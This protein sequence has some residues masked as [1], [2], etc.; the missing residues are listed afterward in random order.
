M[1]IEQ[2]LKVANAYTDATGGTRHK[3]GGTTKE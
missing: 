2:L 1:P 3:G